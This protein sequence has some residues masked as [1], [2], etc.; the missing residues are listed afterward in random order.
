MIM[1]AALVSPVRHPSFIRGQRTCTMTRG[2]ASVF[3]FP[4]TVAPPHPLGPPPVSVIRA[5][6]PNYI[7]NLPHCSIWY[8]NIFQLRW[9]VV[10]GIL[11][12]LTPREIF[13]ILSEYF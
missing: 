5:I 12:S 6:F 9:R 7:R 4:K 13:Y 3:P 10:F 11:C 8:D 1:A 2:G